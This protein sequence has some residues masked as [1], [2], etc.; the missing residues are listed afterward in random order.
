[1]QVIS[2][3]FSLFD[4]NFSVEYIF[5]QLLIIILVVLLLITLNLF[6]SLLYLLLLIFFFGIILC[7]CNNE[8]TA[9]FLWVN[10]L[11]VI[12]VLL[13]LLLYINF[14]GETKKIFFTNFFFYS[15]IIIVF[16]FILDYDTSFEEDFLLILYSD[17]IWF[18]YYEALNNFHTNDFFGFFLSYY[19]FNNILILILGL[20]LFYGS[21]V[22]VLL[23]RLIKVVKFNN[24]N[25]FFDIL[26]FSQ[27]FLY[28]IFMRKQDLFDQNSFLVGVKMVF[29]KND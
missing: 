14:S 6:Y 20:I 27:S 4:L 9:G 24:V 5:I 25:N 12:F 16:L 22:C 29:S 18:D 10:E 21:I 8:L 1:M 11:I 7:F 23:F 13:L 2:Y 28:S 26:K 19:T 3:I 15:F 17:I